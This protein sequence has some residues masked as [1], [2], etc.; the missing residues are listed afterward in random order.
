MLS[1]YWGHPRHSFWDTGKEYCTHQA[2]SSGGGC[3]DLGRGCGLR[4]P[5][6]EAHCGWFCGSPMSTGEIYVLLQWEITVSKGSTEEDRRFGLKDNGPTLEGGNPAY[7][8]GTRSDFLGKAAA[9]PGTSKQLQDS[10]TARAKQ[11]REARRKG[12]SETEG[13]LTRM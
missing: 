3:G 13:K 1:G 11:C 4:L 6:W 2:Q 12:I 10:R 8:D 7:L 5:R 9:R